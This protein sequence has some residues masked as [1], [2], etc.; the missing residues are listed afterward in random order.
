MAGRKKMHNDV[1]KNFPMIGGPVSKHLAYTYL[2]LILILG[3]MTASALIIYPKMS[4]FTTLWTL[5]T[6]AYKM[7][8]KI[9]EIQQLAIMRQK[10]HRIGWDPAAESYTTYD[11]VASVRETLKLSNKIEIVNTT[12]NM[13]GMDAMDFDAFGSPSAEGNV[14]LEDTRGQRKTVRIVGVTGK[15]DVF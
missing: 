15:V 3:V 9:R 2:E 10:P 11:G 14:V 6:E 4:Q 1:L 5:E 7:K 8:G 12:F 13:S